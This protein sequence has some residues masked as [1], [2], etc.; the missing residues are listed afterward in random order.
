MF[1]KRIFVFTILIFNYLHSIAQVTVLDKH[2][3]QNKNIWGDIFLGQGEAEQAFQLTMDDNKGKYIVCL[4]KYG[5]N[6]NLVD[7]VLLNID[8]PSK[9]TG[10]RKFISGNKVRI[11]VIQPLPQSQYAYSLYEVDLKTMEQ[12]KLGTV[13]TPKKFYEDEY[14][15]LGNKI[16]ISGGYNKKTVLLFIDFA[17]KNYKITNY[18]IQGFKL[19]DIQYTY[20][21]PNEKYKE[22]SLILT[23]KISYTG[24]GNTIIILRFNEFGK[25][26]GKYIIQDQ[27]NE[28]SLEKI[29]LS[30][31]G[32]DSFIITGNYRKYRY[33]SGMFFGKLVG[34]KVE[35]LKFHNYNKFNNFLQFVQD[36]RDESLHKIKSTYNEKRPKHEVSF[37]LHE[38]R[39]I[40][41]K[42]YFLAEAGIA[43]YNSS[44][45]EPNRTYY[46]GSMMLQSLMLCIDYEG[47][48]IWN[49]RFEIGNGDL[50]F[51]TFID[52]SFSQNNSKIDLLYSNMS[53][54]VS[55]SFNASDGIPTNK[56]IIKK[57]D[58][59]LTNYKRWVS[60]SVIS[61][62][63]DDKY[64]VFGRLKMI[65]NDDTGILK[66]RIIRYFIYKL[67]YE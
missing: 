7:S 17:Q 10:I 3:H 35:L 11:L 30:P 14:E 64:L 59:S 50:K 32:F 26:F 52:F 27:N 9:R 57:L 53:K 55:Q 38:N 45:E 22:I 47:S 58:F 36:E 2:E 1:M 12:K 61:K 33:I 24:K 62:W 19:S 29:R 44:Y 25:Q 42:C 5:K 49:T 66:K 6:L 56:R 54:V 48:I 39:I 8:E 34:D 13:K 51:D 16:I 37:F 4:K 20:L 23:T 18:D 60:S 63:Y 43:F 31:I 46:S 40:D 41:N 67:K 65:N 21:V 15:I 28:L